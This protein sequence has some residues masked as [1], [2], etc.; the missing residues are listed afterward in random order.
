MTQSPILSETAK[1]PPFCGRHPHRKNG[2][3]VPSARTQQVHVAQALPITTFESPSS[4]A[5]LAQGFRV[6][7]R[8]I[9]HPALTCSWPQY[10]APAVG[11]ARLPVGPAQGLSV[12]KRLII[13]R[14][15]APIRP[16]CGARGLVC[17]PAHAALRK[18]ACMIQTLRIR[19]Q[20]ASEGQSSGQST[21]ARR[22]VPACVP[23]SLRVIKRLIIQSPMG[24]AWSMRGTLGLGCR[25]APVCVIKPLIIHPQQT[26]GEQVACQP[27]LDRLP[28][29]DR[30]KKDFSVI[31]RLIPPLVLPAR[32]APSTGNSHPTEPCSAGFSRFW[33]TPLQGTHL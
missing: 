27:T 5:D 13:L 15:Q 2:Y 23:Q 10:E 8:L 18:V 24:L 20:Q 7:K 26:V 4:P 22:S 30:Q 12:I 11:C 19:A 28:D 33:G 9:I 3:M 21:L 1:Q 14:A 17:A 25:P 16:V 6:I 32:K 29:P 31:K